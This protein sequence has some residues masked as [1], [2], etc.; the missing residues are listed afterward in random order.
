M[1]T[2]EN[3]TWP[4]KLPAEVVTSEFDFAP[5]MA[6]GDAVA[7]VQ[8]LATTVLGT[9]GAPQLVAPGVPVLKGARVYQRLAAG[10]AGCSYRIECRATTVAG[11]V[12]ILARVLPVL[13]F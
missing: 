1:S 11:N 10:L 13:A 7:S 3:F 8:I 2:L 6:F 9:D 12:L 4:A 5:D